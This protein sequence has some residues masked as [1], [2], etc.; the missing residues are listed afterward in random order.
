MLY[1]RRVYYESSTDVSELR[2]T[3]AIFLEFIFTLI[4]H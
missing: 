4:V 3:D 2:Q 1:S